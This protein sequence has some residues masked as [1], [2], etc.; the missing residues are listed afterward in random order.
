MSYSYLRL[1]IP[2]GIAP[3]TMCRYKSNIQKQRRSEMIRSAS[4]VFNRDPIKPQLQL[5]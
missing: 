2:K 3:H 4:V 1:T 5:C